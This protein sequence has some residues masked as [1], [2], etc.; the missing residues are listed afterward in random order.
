MITYGRLKKCV[1][2]SKGMEFFIIIRN[3]KRFRRNLVCRETNAVIG[4]RFKKYS[5]SCL[6][7]F[8]EKSRE[9]L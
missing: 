1:I 9:L 7:Y 5:L 3:K 4:K 2:C 8:R 6:I